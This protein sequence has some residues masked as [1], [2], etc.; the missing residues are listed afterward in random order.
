MPINEEEKRS[1]QYAK[2]VSC[3]HCY[4]EFPQERKHRFAE[5]QKQIDLAR[6]RGEQHIGVST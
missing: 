2:G 4:D 5:R 6:Q 1:D 3:P